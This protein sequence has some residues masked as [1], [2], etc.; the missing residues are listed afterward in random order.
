MTCVEIM[1]PNLHTKHEVIFGE[2]GNGEGRG[3]SSIKITRDRGNDD[4]VDSV[5]EFVVKSDNESD[6]DKE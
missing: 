5:D 6:D 3:I 1:M 4:F 2:S